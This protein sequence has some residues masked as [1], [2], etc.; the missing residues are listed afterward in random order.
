MYKF[1]LNTVIFKTHTCIYTY[2]LYTYIK[3]EDNL[4]KRE[5]CMV[6]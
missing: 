2:R 3:E 4:Y 6:V 1:L 5:K